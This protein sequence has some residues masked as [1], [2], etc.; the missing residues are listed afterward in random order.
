MFNLKSLP[1]C[2]TVLNSS[3]VFVAI[4]LS[5]VN[6][7]RPV[8]DYY[9]QYDDPLQAFRDKQKQLEVIITVTIHIL[10]NFLENYILIYDEVFFY[11]WHLLLLLFAMWSIFYRQ[12]NIWVTRNFERFFLVYW[13]MKARAS[14]VEIIVLVCVGIRLKK[15]YYE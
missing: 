8:L 11:Y 5:N 15:I 1:S 4:A 2:S 7:V 14:E 10:M 12:R 6:D 9:N 13:K 3:V